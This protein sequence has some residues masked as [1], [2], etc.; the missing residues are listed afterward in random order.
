MNETLLEQKADAKPTT[1][2]ALCREYRKLSKSHVIPNSYFRAMKRS[3][4]GKLVAMDSSPNTTASLSQDSL[5]DYLLCSKC[6]GH[7]GKWETLWIRRLRQA[8]KLFAKDIDEVPLSS[9]EYETFRCFLLSIIWRA[10]VCARAEFS[11]VKLPDD[12]LES[13]RAD[14][15]AGK[16]SEAAGIGNR[17]RKLV[18]PSE[19]LKH[20]DLEQFAATPMTFSSGGL[21]GYQLFFGG[22][23]VDFITSK[24]TRRVS[25]IRGFVR[26]EP[27]LRIPAVPCMQVKNF[28]RI[29]MHM[30]DKHVQGKATFGG[31][32]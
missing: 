9:F 14:L 24:I 11:L 16:V 21:V 10:A 8:S 20:G 18:D 19:F 5:D 4:N 13:L 32:T 26:D 22:Y 31:K 30:I 29:G 1:Q 15:H 2:C 3:F 12:V 28:V 23:V 7:F 17:I 25:R 27:T 6:E